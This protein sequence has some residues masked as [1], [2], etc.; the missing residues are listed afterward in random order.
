MNNKTSTTKNDVNIFC[1]MI[2]LTPN[3]FPIDPKIKFSF[4]RR[5]LIIKSP[6]PF[7]IYTR[8]KLVFRFVFCMFI[9]GENL[10]TNLEQV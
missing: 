8:P 3:T 4:I 6:V 2:W 10:K 7:G 1:C 5:L 9:H